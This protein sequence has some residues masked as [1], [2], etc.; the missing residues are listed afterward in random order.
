MLGHTS[1]VVI[2]VLIITGLG[3]LFWIVSMYKKTVQ[4]ML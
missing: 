4:G 3:L 2:V 1:I